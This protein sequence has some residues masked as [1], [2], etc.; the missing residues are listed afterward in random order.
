MLLP[1]QS[2]SPGG[3]LVVGGC[4]T[5]ELATRFGTPLYVLDEEMIRASCRSYRQAF[6]G[7]VPSYE[8]AY[9]SKALMIKALCKVMEQEQMALDVASEGELFTA[10]EA[11]FPPERIKLHGNFKKAALLRMALDNGIGRVVV[12]SLPELDLLSS[13]ATDMGKTADILIRITPGVKADTHERIRTGQ[14]DSKFG[15]GLIGGIALTATRKALELPSIDLHGFHC[16]IGSQMLHT[17]GFRR[18]A[19]VV[20]EFIAHVAAETG[21]VAE[22]FDIGGGLGIRYTHDD[23]PPTV[24]KLADEICTAL[25]AAAEEHNIPLPE[26]ILEPGRSIVGEAGVTLYT[27]GVVKEIPGIRTYVSVDGGL[28]D[29]PRPCLYDAE[30]EALIANRADQ[31]PDTVVR[32]AG[33]HCETDTL[34]PELALAA[35]RPGDI[36]AVQATGAYNYAMASNYNR[37]PRPA[38]VLVNDG[39]ADIVVEREPLADLVRLD[40][41][42]QRLQ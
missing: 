24:D 18:A 30:Y 6:E 42:P 14:E 23:V 8:I 13:I 35:P 31:R 4:D 11:G 21:Y 37:F 27:I 7:K 10:L 40:V 38:V 17:D 41:V 9:A 19:S 26:L 32:V 2:V 3:R 15:L 12:D 16:H 22:Q 34:I 39:R 5:V 20:M 1:N 36:L 25:G 33:A 29:N 28:S